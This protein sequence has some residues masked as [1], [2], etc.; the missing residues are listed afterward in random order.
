MTDT[1]EGFTIDMTQPGM[2]RK[3]ALTV[4]KHRL[5]MAIHFRKTDSYALAMARQWAL[6]AEPKDR[7]KTEF[8]TMKQ[9]LAWVE[10]EVAKFEEN[11]DADQHS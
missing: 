2:R 10:A 3:V 9:A 7:P 11:Q 6:Q 8:K 5:G 1:N 4:L